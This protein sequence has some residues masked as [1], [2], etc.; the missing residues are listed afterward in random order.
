MVCGG[1]SSTCQCA[2]YKTYTLSDMDCVLFDH[3]V[4]R[5]LVRLERSMH[6]LATTLGALA[7]YEPADGGLDLLTQIRHV[8]GVRKCVA[9]YGD[10]L[11]VFQDYA[12]EYLRTH[13]LCPEAEQPKLLTRFERQRMMQ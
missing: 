11:A 6:V 2:V 5:T 10:E 9:D 8:C 1:D 7:D 13:Y 4:N 12:D 3:A